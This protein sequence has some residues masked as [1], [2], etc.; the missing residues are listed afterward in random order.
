MNCFLCEFL[1]TQTSILKL[2]V[3]ATNF[4]LD[5]SLIQLVKNE[6]FEGKLNESSYV[7]L[8]KFLELCDIVKCDGVSED[9]I[10]L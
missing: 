1:G 4:V 6:Q 3:S 8:G 10:R 5:T 2:E 7:H 9:A